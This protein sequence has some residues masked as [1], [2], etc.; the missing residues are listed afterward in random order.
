MPRKVLIITTHF[1]PDAH[2]SAKRVN[3]FCK[4]LIEF[5]WEPV[6]LTQPISASHRIDKSLDCDIPDEISIYRPQHLP[7]IRPLDYRILDYTYSWVLPAFWEGLRILRQQKIDLI[8]S[9]EPNYDA[10]LIGLLLNLMANK[11]WV[12]E[13]RDP[14]L[15]STLK[16]SGR[17][18]V[19]HVI[20]VKIVKALL[21]HA[22]HLITVSETLK[23]KLARV[24]PKCREKTSVIYNGY[25]EDDF[26]DL[27]RCS[28]LVRRGKTHKMRITY[29]GTWGYYRTPEFFLQAL[30][31]LLSTRRELLEKITVDF[32]GEVKLDHTLD[33]KILH[34]I[35]LKGLEGI[36][37]MR[38]F[39]PHREALAELYK[40]DVL[41]LVQMPPAAQEGSL[42]SK[43]FEY[44]RAAKPILA[45]VPHGSEIAAIVEDANAGIIA[46]PT[47]VAEIE[48]AILEMHGRFQEGKLEADFNKSV[49]EIFDR[50]K[51]V[52]GLS[53][54]FNSLVSAQNEKRG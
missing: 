24:F 29:I 25:D 5:G 39:M 10:N 1:A 4:F 51:Q 27:D 43:L 23:K 19:A 28:D 47:N 6:V 45:L 22:D 46:S 21:R 26:F 48:N 41:L 44:L 15:D 40:S 30:E 18:L 54:I 17:F 13:F 49:V 12:C 35:K 11:K 16:Y 38:H 8:F 36:V 53:K 37:N 2:V 50:K 20:F 31:N 34:S 9:T 52:A 32:I 33:K 7:K 42:S 3:K 14:P